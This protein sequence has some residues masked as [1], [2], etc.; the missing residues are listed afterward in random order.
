MTATEWDFDTMDPT[1]WK[2]TEK[3]DG[4]RA[5]W[6]GYEFYSRQGRKIQSPDSFKRQIP[7]MALDGELW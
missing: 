3:Y 6:N 5:Y 1:G 7:Y 2:M 4:M